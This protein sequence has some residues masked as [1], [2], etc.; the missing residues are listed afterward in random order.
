M[1]EGSIAAEHALQFCLEF[2]VGVEG[3]LIL[4]VVI[5][6]D[7]LG[8][9]LDFGGPLEIV[10]ELLGAGVNLVGFA[11]LHVLVIGGAVGRVAGAIFGGESAAP[12]GGSPGPRQHLAVVSLIPLENVAL[13]VVGVD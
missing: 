4:V 2:C 7:V 12:E 3:L 13:L 10:A 1:S 9:P 6:P 11:D 5:G 8:L